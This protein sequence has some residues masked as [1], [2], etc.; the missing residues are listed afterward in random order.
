MLAIPRIPSAG[1]G[2][3]PKIDEAS[4]VCVEHWKVGCGALLIAEGRF[5]VQRAEEG[6]ACCLSPGSRHVCWQ[7]AAIIGG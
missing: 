6:E 2:D 1:C 4:P 5:A 3:L 7:R